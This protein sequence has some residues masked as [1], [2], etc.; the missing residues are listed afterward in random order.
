MGPGMIELLK[1][2]DVLKKKVDI[3][4][5]CYQIPPQRVATADDQT[6]EVI[7]IVFL[8]IFDPVRSVLNV[9]GKIFL[10]TT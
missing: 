10:K 5:T 2:I 4:E 6:I 8:E 3:R 7:G 1:D 9:K